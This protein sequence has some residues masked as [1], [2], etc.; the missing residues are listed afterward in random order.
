MKNIELANLGGQQSKRRRY[1]PFKD[2]T[3]EPST[4]LNLPISLAIKNYTSEPESIK[5]SERRLFSTNDEEAQ[6]GTLHTRQSSI[7]SQEL[8]F[9]HRKLDESPKKDDFE[10]QKEDNEQEVLYVER[11]YCTVCGFEQPLRAKHCRDC[12]RCVAQYDHHC[13]WLGTCIGQKNH[14]VFYWFLIFQCIQLAWG[15]YE[16]KLF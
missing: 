7:K 10:K 14:S 2:E 8:L 12:N 4:K 15:E 6:L 9:S 3:S 1:L 13:P 5:S 11:R 16:V